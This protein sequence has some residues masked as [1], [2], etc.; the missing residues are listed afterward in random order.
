[1]P[2]LIY[3]VKFNIDD[4]LQ[5][6]VAGAERYEQ[7]IEEL[8]LEVAQLTNSLEK[9][10]KQQKQFGQGSKTMGKTVG[11]ANKQV[12]IGN[13]LFFSLSDGIQDSAQFS[14]GFSTG[15][16]AVGN[17]IG[18]TAEMMG[19]FVAQTAAMNN[20]VVN[21]KNVTDG[22]KASFMGVGGLIL[23]LNT[24]ITLFTVYGDEIANAI[25]PQRKFNKELEKQREELGKI[26]IN[27]STIASAI[28]EIRGLDE[29]FGNLNRS[30]QEALLLSED[31]AKIDKEIARLEGIKA[32]QDEFRQLENLI[33]AGVATDQQLDRYREIEQNQLA[34]GT[35]TKE[36]NTLYERQTDLTVRLSEAQLRVSTAIQEGERVD[37]AREEEAARLREERFSQEIEFAT[38]TLP[39][40]FETELE[41]YIRVEEEKRKEAQKTAEFREFYETRILGLRKAQ[42]PTEKEV[43]Q[44]TTEIVRQEEQAKENI[45]RSSMQAALSMAM[46][47]G[48]N[49]RGLAL[50]FLAIEKGLR[51]AEV[52]TTTQAAIAKIRAA[53]AVQTVAGDKTAAIRNEGIITALKVS[54]A[55]SIAAILAQGLAQGASLG[56]TGSSPSVS[57]G[58]AAQADAPFGFQTQEVEGGGRFRSPLFMPEDERQKINVNITN[59]L[60]ATRKDLYILNKLGEE[61][62]R[63]VKL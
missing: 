23:L 37:T 57:A 4:N 38:F 46:L 25:D 49:N 13:Q 30:V 63:Q 12:A 47:L 62:Y 39:T 28:L 26:T 36:L 19:V 22:L 33:T 54:S 51:V 42:V 11:Q 60:R 3:N 2:D 59:E 7:Q 15:M 14:Q 52:V 17:N 27:Y 58:G 18:F 45:R 35:S 29:G 41:A 20:G 31:L 44:A 48:E 9:A 10:T 32:L 61:E 8:Q 55:A 50:A 34:L 16:R 24:A 53:S 40:A 6:G 5:E 56:S 21:F 43:A 1:M